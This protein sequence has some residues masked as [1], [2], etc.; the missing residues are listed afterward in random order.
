[1][2]GY[3]SQK[4]FKDAACT[5]LEPDEETVE[6]FNRYVES[7]KALLEVERKAVE[8]IYANIRPELFGSGQIVIFCGSWY[9][10]RRGCRRSYCRIQT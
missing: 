4:V 9:D 2:E 8:A 7:F 5:T 6:G 3:L 1:M 10:A